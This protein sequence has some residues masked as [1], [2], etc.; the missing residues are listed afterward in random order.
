MMGG[1]P[2]AGENGSKDLFEKR[3]SKTL[4][5]PGPCGG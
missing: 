4:S 2:S 3:K 5:M 1:I